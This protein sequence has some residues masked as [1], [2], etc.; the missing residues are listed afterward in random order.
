MK[1]CAKVNESIQDMFGIVVDLLPTT[2][3]LEARNCSFSKFT[4]KRQG[5]ENL[6]ANAKPN[7]LYVYV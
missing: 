4:F 7:E 1:T 2:C 6:L 3:P 5:R